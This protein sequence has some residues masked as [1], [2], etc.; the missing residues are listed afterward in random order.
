M[1]SQAAEPKGPDKTTPMLY[2]RL[3]DDGDGF[4]PQRNV[5]QSHPGLDGGGSIAAD[6]QRDTVFVAW[7]RAESFGRQRNHAA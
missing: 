5:V 6:D 3:N 4:Q 7:H 2:T 1:G